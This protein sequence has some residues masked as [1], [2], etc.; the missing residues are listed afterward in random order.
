MILFWTSVLSIAL[1]IIFAV[2][3]I[4]LWNRAIA[5]LGWF[6]TKKIAKKKVARKPKPKE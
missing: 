1:A 3:A 2:F 4:W 6:Q 5:S